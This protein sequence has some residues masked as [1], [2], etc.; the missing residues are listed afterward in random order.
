[1]GGDKEH[2]A[3]QS[4]SYWI[5]VVR[6]HYGEEVQKEQCSFRRIPS[7][8]QGRHAVC[9]AAAKNRGGLQKKTP[10]TQ[11]HFGEITPKCFH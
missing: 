9:D 10:H 8:I 2:H 11:K 3:L 7:A 4:F 5:E 1:M 6:V